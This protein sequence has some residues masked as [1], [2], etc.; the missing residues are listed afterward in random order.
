MRKLID[1]REMKLVIQR[2]FH[3]MMERLKDESP[4]LLGIRTRGAYLAQRFSDM[5]SE[6]EIKHDIG[7][8][9]V[10]FHRDD[11]ELAFK[12]PT[13]K[14]T[15]INTDLTDRTVVLLDDVIYTGRT[16]RAALDELMDF[17]RPKKVILIVL[18]DRDRRELPIQPDILGKFV[19]TR[20]DERVYVKFAEHDGE[21]GVY[22]GEE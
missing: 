4:I 15:R 2:M 10:T 19:P 18:V 21:D 6:K 8:L 3:E 1:E 13:V 9:D 14:G 22:I 20:K 5:L 16:V 17:G 12:V 11:A 7:F